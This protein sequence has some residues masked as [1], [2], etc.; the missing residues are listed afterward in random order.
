LNKILFICCPDSTHSISWINQ[1]NDSDF[2]VRVFSVYINNN[3]NLSYPEWKFP[4]Y[5]MEPPRDKTRIKNKLLVY[6]LSRIIPI[7]ISRILID[8]F[9]LKQK[10]LKKIILNWKPDII[11][12]FPLNVGGKLATRTLKSIKKDLW[13]RWVASSWGSDLFLGIEGEK[14]EKDNIKYILENCDGFFSDCNRDLNIAKNNGLNINDAK[15]SLSLPGTGGVD[16][17]LF[18]LI[19]EK[20]LKRNII[21]IPKAY[22]REHANKIFPLLEAIKLIQ[23]DLNQYEIHF[24]MCSDAVKKWINKFPSNLRSRCKTYDMIS[25]NEMFK[26]LGKTKLMISLSISDGTPNVMLEAMAAGALP[27]MHPLDSIKEWIKDGENGLLVN[28]LY[29][30]RIRDAIDRGLKDDSLFRSASKLNWKTISDRA[31]SDKNKLLI[32]KKYVNLLEN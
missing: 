22:E 32:I 13:P 3:K 17:E 29:P 5:V 20:N 24:L 14:R 23:D 10:W 7:P 21:L 27:I 26:L 18:K 8:K 4:T 16:I 25:Q 2:D 11:H 30:E 28:S 12:S 19:R 1:L 15:F 31:D 6:Y 9:G